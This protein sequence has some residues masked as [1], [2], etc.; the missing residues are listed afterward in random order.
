MDLASPHEM[1]LQ[2]TMKHLDVLVDADLVSIQ[3]SGQVNS[4]HGE[5]AALQPASDWVE[6]YSQFWRGQL[7]CLEECLKAVD[8]SLTASPVNDLYFRPTIPHPTDSA[9][10]V[11]Y[12]A[13]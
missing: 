4:C 10:Q 8:S 1:S 6:Y 7:A 9:G 5:F 11:F 12:N 13:G 3:T 2:A